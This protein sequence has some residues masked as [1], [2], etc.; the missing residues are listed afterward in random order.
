MIKKRQISIMGIFWTV[1]RSWRSS[2]R[3]SRPTRTAVSEPSHSAAPWPS[4]LSHLPAVPTLLLVSTLAVLNA[5][6]IRPVSGGF[7]SHPTCLV[8]SVTCLPAQRE[9]KFP[10]WQ[11]WPMTPLP[12]SFPDHDLGAHYS[13][14]KCLAKQKQ[15]MLAERKAAKEAAAAWG[16]CVTFVCHCC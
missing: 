10:S 16:S 7:K 1:P 8:G 2:P 14:R 3:W 15:R 6:L 4:C 12:I 9:G 13:A 11:E 5:L